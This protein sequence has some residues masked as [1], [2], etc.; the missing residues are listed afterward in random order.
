MI[1]CGTY[2]LFTHGMCRSA[3]GKE[4][5]KAD[6]R[7]ASRDDFIIVMEGVTAFL[8]GPGCFLIVWGLLARKPWRQAAIVLVSLGQFYGNVLY[9]GTCIFGGER[10]K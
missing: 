9:F 10:A 3:T 2:S 8:E 6:S 4:Y 1:D 5:A 7:Y